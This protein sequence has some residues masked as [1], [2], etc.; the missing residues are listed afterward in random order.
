MINRVLHDIAITRASTEDF[1]DVLSGVPFSG[2]KTTELRRQILVD[3][4]SHAD[5]RSTKWYS[6]SARAAE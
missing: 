3:Q 5:G 4:K 6:F 2:K 1:M